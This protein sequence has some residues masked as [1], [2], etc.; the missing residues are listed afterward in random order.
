MWLNT[1]RCTLLAFV[2]VLP[3]GFALTGCNDDDAGDKIE[4]GVNDAGR[5]VEDAVD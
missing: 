2:F 4:E 1:L 5:S 3:T